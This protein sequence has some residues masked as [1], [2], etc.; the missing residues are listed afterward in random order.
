MMAALVL[1]PSEA[2]WAERVVVAAALLVPAPTLVVLLVLSARQLRAVAKPVVGPEAAALLGVVAA[3]QAG[4]TLRG[5]LSGLSDE[6]DRMVAIG[7]PSDVVAAA[8][9]R[10]LPEQG[11][12][13]GAAVRMLDHVGGAVSPV[14]EELAAQASDTARV[15][16]ELRSAVAA[17]VLQGVIVGGAPL[18]ALV[19]MIA[20]GRLGD[21]FATSPAH[22][23]AVMVGSIMTLVGVV[24]VATIVRKSSP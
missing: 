17:P 10:A 21:V 18:V 3:L 19:A 16:R 2:S 15:R 11:A 8:V 12:M 14:M 20:T 24:W 6:V 4:R 22:A 1:L 5:A 9:E 7:A 13:A 23:I